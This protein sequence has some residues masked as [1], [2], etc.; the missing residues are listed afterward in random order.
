MITFTLIAL[1]MALL[2]AASRVCRAGSIQC[3]CLCFLFPVVFTLVFL[4]L[5]LVSLSMPDHTIHG[6]CTRPCLARCRP[7]LKVFLFPVHSS[8]SHCSQKHDASREAH[9]ESSS[10]FCLGLCV[11]RAML[12]L[13]SLVLFGSLC[14]ESHAHAPLSGSVWVS[15]C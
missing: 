2:S 7:A 8:C 10:W 3:C 15:V 4:Q 13:H 11:L 12:M 5:C 6:H 9:H 14:A 1:K